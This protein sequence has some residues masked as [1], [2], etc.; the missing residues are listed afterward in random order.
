MAFLVVYSIKVQEYRTFREA[1][2]IGFAGI[3]IEFATAS[4]IDRPFTYKVPPEMSSIIKLG[5][6]VKIPFGRSNKLQIGYVVSLM[7]ELPSSSY[8]LKMIKEVVD[9]V[10]LIDASQWDIIHFM[11]NY[12]GTSVAAAIDTVL[13]PGLKDAPI[14]RKNDQIKWIGLSTDKQIRDEYYTKIIGK[15]KFQKQKWL[16]DYLS[17]KGPVS[18]QSLKNQEIFSLSAF[19]TL[20]EKGLIL[21]EEKQIPFTPDKINEEAFQI[22]QTAQQEAIDYLAA[23]SEEQ[24]YRTVLLQGIT[25]SGKTEVFLHA[26]R[27]VIERGETALVLVP[28]IALTAQT[29]ARFQERFGNRVALTHSRM[30]A[31]ERQQLYIRAQEGELSVVIGPRSAIFMPL[32]HLKLIV[33]DEA[34]DNSYKSE[35]DPKYHAI[36]V[37]QER[38]KR[39][40]GQVLLATA[41]PNLETYYEVQEGRYDLLQLNQR[42]GGASLPEVEIADM[43]LELA[44]GNTT[45]FSQALY[46]AISEALKKDKQVMLLINRRGYAT[47][48]NCRS[49]GYV[50]KC[51]HCDVAMT[52]HASTQNLQC[53]YCGKTAHTPEVCPACGSKHI[54]FFGTGTEKIEAFVKERFGEY[55]IG[56]MDTDT[57]TG[58]EGHKKILE[59]FKKKEMHILIGTQM[60]AKGH[61]FPE[62]TVVGILSAD[63]SLFMQDFRSNERTY[64]LLTQAMGRAGRGESKGKVII[65]TYNPDHF[66][67][68]VIKNHKDAI[69]YE[70]E[71]ANRKIMGYPP[72]S[73]IFSVLVTGSDEGQVIRSIHSLAQ[74]FN[75]YSERGQ[76]HFRVIGPSSAVISKIGDEYRWRLLIL[77]EFREKLM[78]YGRFCLDKF[79]AKESINGIKISWDIDPLAMI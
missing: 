42:V 22:P 28:E 13:P 59:A 34:H 35:V 55:G 45:V 39:E 56:R 20:K 40:N 67:M 72:Y 27:R 57:T 49:C 77:G 23:L 73:H 32:P 25:G 6:R 5:Q 70:Q 29:V 64:Q 36:E 8:K 46:E 53:H 2:M 24:V 54:R 50:I 37:A 21:E 11:V 51:E 14:T 76:H 10:P 4:E 47:F 17:T 58:K 16:L 9:Q 18:L 31:K 69:F 12:Y 41:T 43:R 75:H 38:M 33:I 68:E 7:E 60:I 15:L 3:I 30:S 19:K 78:I 1:Q 61:D 79:Y 52:Y 66:V 26:I 71:L 62:V 65:Q 44:S 63:A 74:Y 48:I